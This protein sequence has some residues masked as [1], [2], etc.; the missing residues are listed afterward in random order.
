MSSNGKSRN[1]RNLAIHLTL[2]SNI[3]AMNPASVAGLPGQMREVAGIGVGLG[4]F[5]CTMALRVGHR[6]RVKPDVRPRY[7]PSQQAE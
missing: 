7:Q 3:G 2:R 6:R 4:N 5:E 1:L